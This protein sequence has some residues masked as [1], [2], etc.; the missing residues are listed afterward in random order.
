MIKRITKLIA[1]YKAPRETFMLLHPLKTL[2]LGALFLA[3]SVL[4][5]DRVRSR[6]NAEP[7]VQRVG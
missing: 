7:E 4:F 3:G 2:K 5:G 6:A 1:Y